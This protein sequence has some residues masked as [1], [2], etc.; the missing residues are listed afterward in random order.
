MGG[1]GDSD[2]NMSEDD[3]NT[4]DTEPASPDATAAAVSKVKDY[5]SS[6]ETW[7]EDLTG[8]DAV[9]EISNVEFEVARILDDDAGEEGRRFKE[10]AEFGGVHLTSV[11][12][13]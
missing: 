1:N 4:N 12:S 7:L 10:T 11:S 5:L 13:T 2:S 6:P 3:S 9:E 8:Q